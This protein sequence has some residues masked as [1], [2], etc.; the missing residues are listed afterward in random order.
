MLLWDLEKRWLPGLRAHAL[1]L[2]TCRIA[3]AG[4]PP[5]AGRASHSR[6]RGWNWAKGKDSKGKDFQNKGFNF[7]D[8]V[9]KDQAQ[10]DNTGHR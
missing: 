9:L 1:H 4:R 8:K 7:K 2:T 3:P 10:G 5:G 6:T